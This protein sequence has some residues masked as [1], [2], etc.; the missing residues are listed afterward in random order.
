MLLFE[1]AVHGDGTA[2]SVWRAGYGLDDGGIGFRFPGSV[3]YFSLFQIIHTNFGS[4]QPTIQ[5][6]LGAFLRG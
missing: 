1:L 5:W 2:Q 4:T 6:V 3:I